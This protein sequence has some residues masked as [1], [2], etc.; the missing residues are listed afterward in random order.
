MNIE[1]Q[2]LL[3][4]G[5]LQL[6]INMESLELHMRQQSLPQQYPAHATVMIASL[7][8]R[9]TNITHNQTLGCEH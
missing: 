9:S 8:K 6:K 1:T 2:S 5:K 3:G 4:S 7:Q